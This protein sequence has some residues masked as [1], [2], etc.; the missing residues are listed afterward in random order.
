MAGLVYFFST[1]ALLILAIVT[2]KI[3]YL[4]FLASCT[5]G[6]A[7]IIWIFRV[8]GLFKSSIVSYIVSCLGS[9]LISSKK[10][11]LNKELVSDSGLNSLSIFFI[12]KY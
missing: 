6:I 4:G 3:I 12:V 11:V 2:T 9:N 7:P 1:K 5:S 10:S 8:S